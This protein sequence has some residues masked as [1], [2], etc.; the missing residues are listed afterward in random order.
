MFEAQ[1]LLGSPGFTGIT[2]VFGPW[3][4]R[5]ADNML[6]TLDVAA[7]SD[8]ADLVIKLWHKNRDDVG[9]GSV[10]SAFSPRTSTGRI[11]KEF[12]GLKELVRYEFQV[13]TGPSEWV[14]FRMLDIVWFDTLGA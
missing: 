8:G 10:H 7:L 11:S 2:V 1:L 12:L 13:G 14:L 9:N 6:A 5:K 4:S 3:L